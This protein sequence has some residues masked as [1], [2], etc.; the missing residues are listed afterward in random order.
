[1]FV[2]TDM[3]PAASFRVEQTAMESPNDLEQA[4]EPGRPQ[5]TQEKRQVVG[6]IHPC[7]AGTMWKPENKDHQPLPFQ[8]FCRL[9]WWWS[10]DKVE[11]GNLTFLEADPLTGGT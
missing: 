5:G 7:V 4:T 9:P 6:G 3:P 10:G 8:R 1:M 11:Y 2:S